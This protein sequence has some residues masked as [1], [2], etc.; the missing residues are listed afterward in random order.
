[1]PIK[2]QLISEGA[3]TFHQGDETIGHETWQI[4]R[5][6]RA[7][8]LIT[9]SAELA[10]PNALKWNL[11][12]D[13]SQHYAPVQLSIHI[14]A[15][16]KSIASEQHAADA[17]WIARTQ[18]HGEEPVERAV[19]FSPKHEVDFPSALFNA[20]TLVRLNL[21]VGQSSSFNVVYIDTPTLEP[22]SVTQKYACIAEEKI[23][24]PAGTFSAWHYTMHTEREGASAQP[25]ENNFWADRHG[26]VLLYQ[27]ADG[28][29]M[30]LA[31]YKRIERH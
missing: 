6:A 16:G 19:A 7:G 23:V 13:I 5:L 20:V 1:M 9:S 14:D 11:N 28:L 22:Q 17:Q 8:L 29:T 2:G 25:A 30:K 24:V 27:A 12:Y 18:T 3:Y 26:I 31:R 21:Q 15:E 4:T 10:R